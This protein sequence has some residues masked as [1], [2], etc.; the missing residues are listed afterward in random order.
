MKP[1]TKTTNEFKAGMPLKLAYKRPVTSPEVMAETIGRD[2]S[3]HKKLTPPK[4]HEALVDFH[5]PGIGWMTRLI[6][7]L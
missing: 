3:P 1:L 7:T 2:A 5:N 4:F 6:R